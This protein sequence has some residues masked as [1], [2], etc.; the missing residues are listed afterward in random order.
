MSR[1]S[2]EIEADG[3]TLIVVGGFDVPLGGYH[4]S[5]FEDEEPVYCNLLN[6]VNPF[7][8]SLDPLIEGAKRE[9]YEIP[10]DFIKF[11][12]EDGELY[13]AGVL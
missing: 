7:P 11:L 6:E 1:Y 5:V 2:R 10:K 4:L 12:K 8:N 3:K 9:G 13:L